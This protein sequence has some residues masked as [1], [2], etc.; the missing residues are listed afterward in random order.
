MKA[1]KLLMDEHK[2]IARA[3]DIIERMAERSEKHEEVPARDVEDILQFL[4]LFADRHHQGREEAVLFPAM[5]KSRPQDHAK[6]ANIVFEHDQ[7]RSLVSGIQ[8]SLKTRSSSDF[9]YFVRRLVQIL[10]SH[11]HKEDHVLFELANSMLSPEDDEH[12]A[13]ELAD[14]ERGWTETKLPG[15]LD[16]LAELERKYGGPLPAESAA[17]P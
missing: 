17:K 8:D 3:L 6:V 15:L 11:I 12:V 2:Q 10:R 5:L 16:R 9:A 13:R 1:T 14:F 4:D 7:E